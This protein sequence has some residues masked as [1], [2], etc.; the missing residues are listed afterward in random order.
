MIKVTDW[1]ETLSS[2]GSGFDWKSNPQSPIM[3]MYETQKGYMF[4]V[5]DIR[6]VI[7]MNGDIFTIT[8]TRKKND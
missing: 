6:S 4:C 5:S 1:V 2:T 8:L 3:I 7:S